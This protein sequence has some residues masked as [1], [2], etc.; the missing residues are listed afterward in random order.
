[1]PKKILIIKLG[2]SETLT[3]EA[4]QICSLGDVFR[5]TVIL[6]LFEDD[7]VTW[8]TDRVAVPLLEGNPYIRRILSFDLMSTLQ[9]ES[10]RFDV[11]INLE[12]IPGICALVSR[13]NA[14]KY[15]GFRF[16]RETGTAQAYE[17]AYEA[18]EISKRD[19]LKKRNSKGWAEVLYSLLG[20]EWRGE[21]YILGY[22]PKS[23]PT[24]D[25][26]FNM[27]VGPK[28]PLKA[29]PKENWET[30][31]RALDGKFTVTWQQNLDNLRGYMDWINTCRILVTNDSLGLHLAKA[32]EKKVVAMIGPS[33][34]AELLPHP[35]LKVIRPALERDCMPC[36]QQHCEWQDPCMNHISP[37]E[38]CRTIVESDLG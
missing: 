27:H 2:Y 18:L 30:L 24:H 12:K 10:E 4:G 25:V 13:I 29:W 31:S 9:L 38:V 7:H 8:L 17:N 34:A 11:V 33:S 5:S 22:T 23:A 6:H 1:M 21:R 36:Y 14:W 28:Y 26:G 37:D 16:D 3:Q 35:L 15:Y 20:A 32:M 19:E